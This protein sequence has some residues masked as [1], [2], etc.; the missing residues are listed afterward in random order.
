MV[1]KLKILIAPDSFKESLSSRE[2]A[3]NLSIGIRRVIPGAVF[4]ILPLSDGGEGFCHTIT[5]AI[6]GY[7]KTY[8]VRDALMRETN[9]D[10]GFSPDGKTA[11]IEMALANGLEM[12]PQA[13][14]NPLKTTTYGTGELIR[15]AISE[16][17]EKIIMGI[18]GSATNDGGAGMAKALGI[19]FL[20]D[21][22]NEIIPNG[23]NLLKIKEIDT[24]SALRQM[25]EIIAACDVNNPFTGVEGA[26]AVYGP[27]KGADPEMVALLEQNLVHFATL[28]RKNRYSDI[29]KIPGAGAAGGLG[30]GLIAFCN[31]RLINGFQLVANTVNLEKRIA[32]AD[33]IITGEGKIDLQTL[34]GKVPY[35]VAKLAEKYQK[36]LLGVAGTLGEGHEKL[37]ENGFHMLLSIL[38]KPVTLEQAIVDTPDLL[39]ETGDRIGRIIKI[40]IP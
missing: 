1:R 3:E 17:C 39:M 37:Y 2:V 27:Q 31:A 18:G 5:H 24:T 10:I 40:K 22:G 16:G 38:N 19:K 35:G 4:D 8:R 28:L 11:F 21:S 32:A 34:S 12:I 29:E 7:L 26:S 15:H 9:A 23:G 25:P 20:D 36:T 6:S 13:L 30:G 14:R 33:L